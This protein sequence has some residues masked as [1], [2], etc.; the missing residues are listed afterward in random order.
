MKTDIKYM[1]EK[2]WEE[3]LNK[4]FSLSGVGHLGFGLEYNIW[5]YKA[6][7]HV[8]KELLIKNNIICKDKKILDIGVGTG[9]YI[10]FWEKLGAK[11]ITGIDITN[12]SIE[13]LKIK[14]P[15]HRFAKG[16]ISSLDYN[17]IFP[18]EKF[19]IITAFDVLFHI[20]DEEDFKNAIENIRRFSHQGTIILIMDNF[21]KKYKSAKGHESDRT[22]SYY[23]KILN[24]YFIEIKEIKPLFYFM[25]TPIDIEV[26]NNSLLKYLINMMW[27]LNLKV[28]GCYRRLGKL[29]GIIAYLWASILYFLDRI[30]LKYT[31]I[32]PGT[33]LLLAKLKAK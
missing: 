15:N 25:N 10:S 23:K 30:I 11:Q 8:L 2:Y 27:W 17:K 20:V 3:R 13:E 7:L 9:F 31:N 32:G 6:R 18:N 12:K 24:S 21:L 5:L 26:I 19:D 14:Y 28:R 4:D 22:L 33:K 1:P 29:G 16:N